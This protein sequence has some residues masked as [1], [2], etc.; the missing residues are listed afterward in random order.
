MR[1]FITD[2]LRWLGVNV[3]N[4]DIRDKSIKPS[5]IIDDFDPL[6]TVTNINTYITDPIQKAQCYRINLVFDSY[7][8]MPLLPL[9]AYKYFNDY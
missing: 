1:N 6:Y 8:N 9:R 2:Y 3:I 7:F 4:F 5:I